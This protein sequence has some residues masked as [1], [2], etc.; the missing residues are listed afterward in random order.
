MA[1]EQ[2]RYPEETV[3]AVLRQTHGMIAPAAAKLGYTR[4]GLYAYIKRHKLEPVIEEEREA[5]LDWAEMH[6]WK[7][8]V[9]GNLTALIFFLKCQGKSRGYV[10]RQDVHVSIQQTAARVAE[11]FGMTPEEV[12][13]E[14]EA[15]LREESHGR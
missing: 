3:I 1:M 8:I 12:L 13:A 5:C 14:A 7:Q 11:E 6:L 15:M 2:E 4:A 10:E 9:D